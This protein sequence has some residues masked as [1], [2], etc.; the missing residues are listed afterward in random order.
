MKGFAIA[1]IS[2]F[3]ILTTFSCGGDTAINTTVTNSINTSA[4]AATPIPA[5]TIDELASG[6]KIYQT[7]CQNCHQEDGT[8]GPV[9]IEGKK[10]DPDDLTSAKIKSFS[11]EK[12]LGYIMNGVPDEGM[13]AFK[14]QLSEG[15]MRDVV[16]FIRT[17]IQGMPASDVSNS[18]GAKGSPATNT[19]TGLAAPNR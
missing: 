15:E 14:G 5:A 18:S 1:F 8:G 11:D 3:A 2:F 7:S 17:E 9:E 13:P 19:S 16:R 10:I 12:I 4:P 6:R